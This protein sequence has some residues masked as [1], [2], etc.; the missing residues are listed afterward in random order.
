ME[1]TNWIKPIFDLLKKSLKKTWRTLTPFEKSFWA[2]D[3]NHYPLLYK[4]HYGTKV[5]FR[6]LSL[7]LYEREDGTQMSKTRMLYHYEFVHNERAKQVWVKNVNGFKIRK[8][9]W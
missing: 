7:N 3:M 1:R 6:K 5:R 4:T 2:K 8:R 9:T